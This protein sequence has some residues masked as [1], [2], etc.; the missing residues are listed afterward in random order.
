MTDEN[1][2]DVDGETQWH[3]VTQRAYDRESP[4]DL[5]TIIIGAVADAE[6]VE[7]TTIREP[8]LYEVVDTSAIE[9]S[10]FGPRV[11]GERRDSG[12]SVHFVYRGHRVTVRSDG[13]VQ[14]AER[15]E[16][17]QQ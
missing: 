3:V 12:G 6:G 4:D 14:V 17:D 10:F 5:T 9:D 15:D 1:A 13:W 7:M 16:I 8:A 2:P 11:G